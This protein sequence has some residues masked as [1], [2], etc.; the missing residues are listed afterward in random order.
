MKNIFKAIDLLESNGFYKLADEFQDQLIK[1]AAWPYNLTSLDE[2]PLG[3]RNVS[4]QDNEEDYKEYDRKFFDEFKQR[5][6]D[7]RALKVDDDEK[8]NVEGKMHGPDS[9]PGPAYVE[10]TWMSSSPSMNGSLDYFTWEEA[11]DSNQGP[12]Y[13][14][15]LRPRG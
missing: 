7:Y 1:L 2:L 10:P 9:V 8:F 14:K 4:Y 13:W 5:N 12:E 6:P 15:N 3:A 11:R